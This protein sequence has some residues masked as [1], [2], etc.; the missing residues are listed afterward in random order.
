MSITK[1][2]TRVFIAFALFIQLAGCKKVVDPEIVQTDFFIHGYTRELNQY[3][4]FIMPMQDGNYSILGNEDVEGTGDNIS[5]IQLTVNE[6]GEL[7]S[8]KKL[9]DSIFSP[10]ITTLRDRSI[11]VTSVQRRN[12][13][14]RLLPDGTFDFLTNFGGSPLQGNSSGIVTGDNK[15]YLVSSCNGGS[16]GSPSN[17]RIHGFDKSGKHLGYFEVKDSTLGAKVLWFQVYRCDSL[18]D[19]FA[20]GWGM[21]NWNGD[22]SAQVQL[23]FMHQRYNEDLELVYNKKVAIPFA[24]DG[25]RNWDYYPEYTSDNYLIIGVN[26]GG[27]KGNS[28][29]IVY[30]FDDDLNLVWERRLEIGSQST[31]IENVTQTPD[32]HYIVCGNIQHT[33]K[34]YGQPFAAKLNRDGDV[35]WSKIYN[36]NGNIK[37]GIIT[38]KGN[39]MLTG[40]TRQFG[41]GAS[42]TDIYMLKTD[43]NGN[44]N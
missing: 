2:I 38:N 25:Y 11:L 42:G 8:W 21:P 39:T 1:F 26:Q 36:I 24:S 6:K 34:S 15:Y 23:F 37:H 41:S 12:A 16:Q 40:H 10:Q 3:A 30:Q 9:A 31:Y 4:H 18:G 13:F 22:W 35:V 27:K 17:N 29:G 20:H 33:N 43:K 19:Y 28:R 14:G 5:L 32:N 44:L 7:L